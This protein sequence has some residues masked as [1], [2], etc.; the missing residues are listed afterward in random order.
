MAPNNRNFKGV[1][2]GKTP[3]PTVA[4]KSPPGSSTN[5]AWNSPENAS[6]RNQAQQIEGMTE[7][8][9]ESYGEMTDFGPTPQ[10]TFQ[11]LQDFANPSSFVS[12][13]VN[14]AVAKAGQKIRDEF[15]KLLKQYGWGFLIKGIPIIGDFWPGFTIRALDEVWP[16]WRRLIFLKPTSLKESSITSPDSIIM[17]PTAVFFDGLMLLVGVLGD[18]WGFSDYGTIGWLG[19][20][21]FGVW[22]WMRS[23]GL[24]GFKGDE[25]AKEDQKKEEATKPKTADEEAADAK[26]P[27]T[28]KEIKKN[29]GKAD[30]SKAP[31]TKG[32]SAP[33]KGSSGM[34]MGK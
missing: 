15:K 9:G 2:L 34:K 24:T 13:K 31:S 33:S 14:E 26:K 18:W 29:A 8:T 20:F 1:D 16:E 4:P 17:V 25:G 27:K 23:G 28:N 19:W 22:I 11:S 6:R 30:T 7:Q 10:P 3:K 12:G 21:I 5:R 32:I